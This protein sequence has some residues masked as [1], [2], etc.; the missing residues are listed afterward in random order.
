M[1]ASGTLIAR[2]AFLAGL[3][4]VGVASAIIMALLAMLTWRHG[5]AIYDD[6]RIVGAY[7][8]HQTGALSLLT[9][10]TVLTAGVAIVVTVAL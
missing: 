10:A 7:P 5:R 1:A 2:G 9:A 6:R 4:T 3:D 8:H